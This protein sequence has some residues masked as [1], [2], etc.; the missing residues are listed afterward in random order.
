VMGK[1]GNMAPWRLG[2]QRAGHVEAAP[3]TPAVRL[4][5]CMGLSCLLVTRVPA[6]TFLCPQGWSGNFT[7]GSLVPL[8]ANT[9]GLC[10]LLP[11]YSSGSLS[12]YSLPP[13]YAGA[14]SLTAAPCP[15]SCTGT[16]PAPASAPLARVGSTGCSCPGMAGVLNATTVPPHFYAGT[17]K[18]VP[19]PAGFSGTVNGSTGTGG[20]SGCVAGKGYSGAVKATDRTPHFQITTPKTAVACPVGSTGT[21]PGTSGTGGRSGCV[22]KAGHSGSVVATSTPPFFARTIS[23]MSCPPG[24]RGTCGTAALCRGI[25]DCIAGVYECGAVPVTIY[26]RGDGGK[27]GCIR[28]SGYSGTV[29][30]HTFYPMFYSS[31]IQAILCPR[32]F[33]GIVPGR[34]GTRP[35]P[36]KV[37]SDIIGRNYSAG[38]AFSGCTLAPGFAAGAVAA[39]RT[40]PYYRNLDTAVEVP[41]PLGSTGNV[42][43]K[44]GTSGT[45]GCVVTAGYCGEVYAITTAP[46]YRST[47]RKKSEGFGGLCNEE[48]DISNASSLRPGT[49]TRWNTQDALYQ[50]A[51]SIGG[52]DGVVRIWAT[53]SWPQAVAHLWQTLETATG[54]PYVVRASVFIS[55]GVAIQALR[56][57]RFCGSTALAQNTGC[58]A[59]H[60]LSTPPNDCDLLGTNAAG[61]RRFRPCQGGCLPRDSC[62]IPFDA[63]CGCWGN[64][65]LDVIDAAACGGNYQT[66]SLGEGTCNRQHSS[67]MFSSPSSNH[68]DM[69]KRGGWITLQGA[70]TAPSDLVTLRLH[71]D[72]AGA[73]FDRV[74][75]E[76]QPEPEPEP[77]PCPSGFF[78][79]GDDNCSPWSD[80][81]PGLG[82]A[83]NGSSYADR[84]CSLVIEAGAIMDGAIDASAFIK[85]IELALPT[86]AKLE[87]SNY[88]QTSSAS[89]AIINLPTSQ[90][91]GDEAQKSAQQFRF[92]VAAALNH[93]VNDIVLT[94]MLARAKNASEAN[95]TTTGGSRRLLLAGAGKLMFNYTVMTAA[96]IAGPEVARAVIDRDAFAKTLI[97]HI[98]AAGAPPSASEWQIK[99]LSANGMGS[100]VQL[101]ELALLSGSTQLGRNAIAPTVLPRITNGLA[102]EMRLNNGDSAETRDAVSC[103]PLPCSISY[104]FNNDVQVTGI[105]MSHLDSPLRFPRHLKVNMKVNS[106]SG[107]QWVPVFEVQTAVVPPQATRQDTSFV[108]VSINAGGLVLD[109]PSFSTDVD[110]RVTMGQPEIVASTKSIA[111]LVSVIKSTLDNAEHLKSLANN[112]TIAG[113]DHITAVIIKP[114]RHIVMHPVAVSPPPPQ[115]PAPESGSSTTIVVVL[116]V[117]V[118][119]CGGLSCRLYLQLRQ[120]AHAGTAVQASKGEVITKNSCDVETGEEEQEDRRA[121]DSSD[122]AGEV[123]EDED[124]DGAGSTGDAGDASS[125]HEPYPSSVSQSTQESNDPSPQ[126]GGHVDSVC[127]RCLRCCRHKRQPPPTDV[128]SDDEDGRASDPDSLSDDAY[129]SGDGARPDMWQSGDSGDD[130]KEEAPRRSSR[131]RGGAGER[132]RRRRKRRAR[133]PGSERGGTSPGPPP[134]RGART[135]QQLASR[136][137]EEAAWQVV[138][139]EEEEPAVQ[140]EVRRPSAAALFWGARAAASQPSP[141]P[142]EFIPSVSFRGHLKGFVFRDGDL[143]SGY[144]TGSVTNP[145]LFSFNVVSM[146]SKARAP[147]RTAWNDERGEW[148]AAEPAARRRGGKKKSKRRNKAGYPPSGQQRER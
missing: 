125:D 55:P 75:V 147:K 132:R 99:I 91:V 10:T 4:L 92:G 145:S 85:S 36:S 5:R 24:A 127:D 144:Y 30:A 141:A 13:Y 60:L 54:A 90:L 84:V 72:Q 94:S 8:A 34:D 105:R 130:S 134:G 19:C 37:P 51:N 1:R 23:A 86:G 15:A 112:V 29:A 101:T 56:D 57:G 139:E 102:L 41:C 116:S 100:E 59:Q 48:L 12:A 61:N 128:G 53:A 9:A 80:C 17:P 111:N 43:G 143:G 95:A 50:T 96:S 142:S 138:E 114:A 66:I 11:G 26:T 82:V 123:E 63:D 14:G 81:D 146:L 3:S 148:D 70:F 74:S 126:K 47:I 77:M 118:L 52:R 16:V 108:P 64:G 32:G 38:D 76:V 31:T 110:Y 42:G 25:Y 49:L 137:A 65:G 21:V 78:G 119:V 120:R 98:N 62:L 124:S 35:P 44:S 136:P 133:G 79:R 135:Q 106:Q 67:L 18:P 6:A 20:L 107:S 71:V 22:V 129:L 46:F 7:N 68:L 58:L 104:A 131:R 83:M 115:P 39:T 33:T 122:P 103:S 69:M 2:V 73:F 109:A 97:L 93:S 140:E 45:S 87:M 40:A 121:K 27:S 28:E 117:C 113:T 89:A 88:R